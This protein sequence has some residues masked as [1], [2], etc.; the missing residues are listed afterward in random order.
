MSRRNDVYVRSGRT[1]QTVGKERPAGLT[2]PT[3]CHGKKTDK[4]VV[5]PVRATSGQGPDDA[6]SGAPGYDAVAAR[7]ANTTSQTPCPSRL[8]RVSNFV[9]G[10]LSSGV[11]ALA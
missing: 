10:R 4:A 2:L 1:R 3:R 5:Q 9:T 6:E 8:P 11:V 7:F